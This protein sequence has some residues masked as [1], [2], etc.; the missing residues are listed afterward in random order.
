MSKRSEIRDKRQKRRQRQQL[1]FIIIILGILLIIAAIVILPYLQPDGEFITPELVE[2]PMA[3][4][5]AMGDPNAP[6]IMEEYSDYQCTFCRKF[7]EETEPELV[8]QYV[9]AGKLY[10]V[11]KNFVLYPSSTPFAEAALCA[12]EQNKFWEYHD[13]LYTNQSSSNPEKYSAQ[14]LIAYAEVVGLDEDRFRQCISERRYQNEVLRLGAEAENA[15]IEVTPTFII[16]GKVV[17]GAQPL[18]VFQEEI[19][20]A[21]TGR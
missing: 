1:T 19:E 3:D 6:V 12:A 4:G 9:T 2:R 21:L 8:K 14:R 16:N 5:P 20:A 7:S 18:E 11:F 10:I 17:Q 13:I 15:G